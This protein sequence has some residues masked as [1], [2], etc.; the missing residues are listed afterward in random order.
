MKSIVME[1]KGQ[2]KYLQHQETQ[3]I[4]ISPNEQKNV[5]HISNKK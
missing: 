3:K 4:K 2:G 5:T 1:E